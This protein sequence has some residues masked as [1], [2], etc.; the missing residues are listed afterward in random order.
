ME[1][2]IE[3]FGDAE[4]IM[5]PKDVLERMALKRGDTIYVTETSDGIVLSPHDSD[6][7]ETLRIAKHVMSEDRELLKKLAE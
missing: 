4:G 3:K 7:E 5:L 1:L 6:L 2:T